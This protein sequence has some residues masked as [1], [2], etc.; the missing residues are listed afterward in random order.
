M[1]VGYLIPTWIGTIVFVLFPRSDAFIDGTVSLFRRS[2]NIGQMEV[3][4]RS[5]L[6]EEDSEGGVSRKGFLSSFGALTVAS[7]A[8]LFVE[9]ADATVYLDPAMYGDQELRVSAVDSLRES[10][11]RAILQDPS[12]C[13]AFYQLALLDGLS[14]NS[15]TG[16][17]G[18]DGTIVRSILSSKESNDEIA[19]LK[20]ACLVIIES[21]K[22][23]KKL[24]SITVA[25]AV[26]LAGAQSVESVGG[27]V[28]SVQ[29]GRTD[30]AITDPLSPLPLNLLSSSGSPEAVAKA[31]RTSG[32]TERE[33]VALLGLL[34]TLDLVEKTTPTENWKKSSKAQFRERGKMGR[35]S[36]YKRLSDEDIQD[37][38]NKEFD[39]D[40][41]TPEEDYI[42]DTFGTRDQAFGNRIS[43]DTK[44]K[45]FN[46]FLKDLQKASTK[47]PDFQQTY[48]WIGALMLDKNSPTI[49][50][51][52]QKYAAGDLIYRKDLGIAYGAVTQLGAEYT[53]GKYENLL[54]NK[55]RR[56]LNDD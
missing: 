46:R 2:H 54:K 49:Y 26:A 21:C 15:A 37:A 34:L 35:M 9:K 56:S 50:T 16:K 24:S 18:P 55:P 36:E 25:D 42:A 14:Y 17:G 23:L 6:E 10:V 11:R 29:L 12:L 31:F 19:L 22:K 27:P 5:L 47:S 3:K 8:G 43:A 40:E 4:S 20:N 45:D 32:M 41:D 38:L 44:K 28:L 13:P 53:G 48:G 39:D 52:L 30:G 33:M 1:R 51:W 7:T